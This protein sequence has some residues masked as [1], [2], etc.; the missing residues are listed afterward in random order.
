[1]R[2]AGAAALLT[3]VGLAGLV[4]GNASGLVQARRR[5][6]RLRVAHPGEWT[7][8]GGDADAA[9]LRLVTI[10]DS[11]MAGDG[12]PDGRRTLPAEVA[13][14]LAVRLG[15]PVQVVQLGVSGHTTTDVL[16]TQ[17]PR[18]AAL[19]PDV[20]ALSVGVN[21]ALKRRP[22]HRVAADHRRLVA[23]I[24]DAVPQATR[25]LV[26]APDLG[27]APALPRPA[28]AVLGWMTGRVGARQATWLDGSGTVVVPVGR[29]E[30]HFAADGFHPGP[31]GTPVIAGWVVEAIADHLPP[32]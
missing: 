19:A 26:G 24:A 21:D 27:L 4:A 23:A 5:A 12:I 20:V 28:N 6:Q 22:L 16:A 3:G 10:G 30:G 15:R 2:P 7:A 18:L 14:A 32:T 29:P 17:V 31:T 9:P 11:V 1:M 8:D 25:V 13:R